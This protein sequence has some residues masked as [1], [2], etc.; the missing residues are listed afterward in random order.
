MNGWHAGAMRPEPSPTTVP[1]GIPAIEAAAP[2]P[3]RRE[4]LTRSLELIGSAL[5]GDGEP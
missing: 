5:A 1:S 3:E 2:A 4:V